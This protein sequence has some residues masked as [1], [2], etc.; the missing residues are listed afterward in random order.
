ML[1]LMPLLFWLLL[2]MLMLFQFLLVAV[3]LLQLLL[4]LFHVACVCDGATF[5]CPRFCVVVHALFLLPVAMLMLPPAAVGIIGGDLAM[6]LQLLPLLL[7][8]LLP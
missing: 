4:I 6:V 8:L 2:L 7:L 1:I 3:V 5:A